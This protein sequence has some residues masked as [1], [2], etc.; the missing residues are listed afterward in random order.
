M[1]ETGSAW[2]WLLGIVTLGCFMQGCA[3]P[4]E[5][6][7]TSKTQLDLLETV[8]DAVQDFRTALDRY[9]LDKE[10]LVG[11]EARIKLAQRAIGGSLNDA[12][13]AETVGTLYKLYQRDVEPYID[14]GMDL[15]ALENRNAFL[16]KELEKEQRPMVKASLTIEKN[17]VSQELELLKRM[18]EE[19]KTTVERFNGEINQI[20]TTSEENLKMLDVLQG[21]LAVMKALQERV[22][23][24]LA[25]DVT[26]SQEQADAMEKSIVD[27]RKALSGGK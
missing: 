20:R 21:Q 13:K 18:P 26:I 11:Q 16:D 3:T 5:I 24:W 1:K 25:I 12:R 22:D 10:K 9:Y 15:M 2:F 4:L 7:Q 23:K 19:V 17:N 27:A 8:D 6:R 14:N